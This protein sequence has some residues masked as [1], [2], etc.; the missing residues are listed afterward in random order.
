MSRL[1]I[2]VTRQFVHPKAWQ[3]NQPII[4]WSNVLV[5]WQYC[6]IVDT[7]GPQ[8]VLPPEKVHIRFMPIYPM[9]LRTIVSQGRLFPVQYHGLRGMIII[10]HLFCRASRIWIEREVERSDIFRHESYISYKSSILAIAI[11]N[12]YTRKNA[13]RQGVE[14]D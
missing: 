5:T 3:E 6:V 9:I 1:D 7:P 2:K 4:L 14:I 11:I 8:I 13:R 10:R 12:L